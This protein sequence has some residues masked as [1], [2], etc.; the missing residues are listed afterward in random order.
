MSFI[1]IAFSGL[2]LTAA[3]GDAMRYRIPNWISLALLLLFVTAAAA[4]REPLGGYWPH[5]ASGAVALLVGYGLFALTGMGA[6]DAKLAAAVVLWSGVTA[7]YPL[8]VAFAIAMAMLAFGLIAIRLILAA[9]KIEPKMRALQR[10]APAP[11]GVAI[12]AA[13][14]VTTRYFDTSLW[15]F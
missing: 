6:G 4:S 1:W 14:V 8:A 15:A 10:K 12:A 5:L 2:L 3:V 7:L 9:L 11:L 13:A